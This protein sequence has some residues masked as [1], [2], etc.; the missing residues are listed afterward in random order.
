MN[1]DTEVAAKIIE[2]V[3]T[4][5]DVAIGQIFKQDRHRKLADARKIAMSLCRDYTY[6]PFERLGILFKRDHTTIVHACEIARELIG[7]DPVFAKNYQLATE[8]VE[9]L[10]LV[11][12]EIDR[13]N[14][15][16]VQLQ[17]TANKWLLLEH[18][19]VIRELLN[20]YIIDLNEDG[21]PKAAI[22]DMMTL[23]DRA[24]ALVNND[25]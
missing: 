7:V 24:V 10:G 12:I 15:P 3:G 4:V 22:A 23:I 1:K 18:K 25:R 20:T 2:I 11:K 13:K 8:E 6:L 17:R 14:G 9:K 5:T 16:K 21:T 19:E